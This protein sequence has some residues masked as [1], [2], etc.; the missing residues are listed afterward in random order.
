MGLTVSLALLAGCVINPYVKTAAVPR[1]D[2][3]AKTCKK[4]AE[5]AVGANEARNYA[6]C[7]RRTMESKAG[8]YAWMNNG[9][10]VL[11][12]QMAGFA[13]YSGVRGGHQAQVAAFTTGGASMY[14]AQQYLYRKPR[15]VIYWSGSNA[16]GCAIG[17]TQRRT[18]VAAAAKVEFDKMVGLYATEGKQLESLLEALET[19]LENPPHPTQ[20]S[21]AMKNDWA[22]LKSS[23]GDVLLS[24]MENDTRKDEIQ[25]RVQKLFFS[26]QNADIDLIAITNAIRDTVNRQ[27]ALE[28]PDPAELGKILGALKL[29]ALAGAASP[30][31]QKAAD[32]P[33]TI[34]FSAA[35]A[36]FSEMRFG[37]DPAINVCG[38]QSDYD[39]IAADVR[40]VSR[41]LAELDQRL[42][43]MEL[44]LDVLEDRAKSTTEDGSQLKYCTLAK[45]NTLMP[46]GLQ[47][48]QQ[49]VQKVAEGQTLSIAI[50]GGVPPF[51][52]AAMSTDSGGITAMPKDTDDGGYKMEISAVSAKKGAKSMFFASDAVGAGA[53]FAVEVVGK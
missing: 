46:F 50:G 10:S 23:F 27:L 15:E 18:V 1:N 45:T 14:G 16:I 32:I 52:V 38:N 49:G 34:D 42:K 25:K 53:V 11:L 31:G 47:L 29:P 41:I 12:M 51:A 3:I 19:R 17:V 7:V 48:A 36:M 33:A 43:D 13:G 6:E 21:A 28:Q 9:G 5:A 39:A 8:R 20:C 44:N 2:P 35:S 37:V 22:A 4:I 40:N 30:S 24:A 26:T